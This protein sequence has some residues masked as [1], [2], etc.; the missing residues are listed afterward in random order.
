MIERPEPEEP[1]VDGPSPQDESGETSQDAPGGE[2]K[3]ESGN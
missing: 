1:P 3:P 2:E